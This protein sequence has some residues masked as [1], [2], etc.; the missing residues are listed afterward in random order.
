M[1]TYSVKYHFRD[2]SAYIPIAMVAILLMFGLIVHVNTTIFAPLLLPKSFYRVIVQGVAGIRILRVTG[3]K[4]SALLIAENLSVLYFM[5]LGFVAG[6]L[7]YGVH[8]LLLP[9]FLS[10]IILYKAPM[11]VLQLVAVNFVCFIA[12]NAVATSDLITIHN[13]MIRNLVIKF[14]FQFFAIAGVLL[15]L[16][17]GLFHW[18]V[19]LV[20]CAMIIAIWY[21]IARG[22]NR[23]RYFENYLI[24]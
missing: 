19:L 16:A 12:G 24:R 9:R 13:P 2:T 14:A 23:L 21:T 11:W 20:A 8:C 3:C 4:M 6:V 7:L 1:F 15:V 22:Y 5:M 18:S 17:A 10:P